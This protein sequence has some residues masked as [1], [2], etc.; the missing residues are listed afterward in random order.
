MRFSILKYVLVM[1]WLFSKEVQTW[2][3]TCYGSW[4]FQCFKWQWNIYLLTFP[5]LH[6][7]ALPEYVYTCNNNF[8]A[9]LV[10]TLCLFSIIFFNR[11]RQHTPG[12]PVIITHNLSVYN[13]ITQYLSLIIS[14]NRIKGT[15]RVRLWHFIIPCHR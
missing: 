8:S 2:P 9:Y 4:T 6:Q 5:Q 11:I 3:R 15:P 10:S 1:F 14:L 12:M 13:V 7:V